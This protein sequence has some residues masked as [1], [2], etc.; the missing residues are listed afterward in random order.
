M[1][2]VVYVSTITTESEFWRLRLNKL[3]PWQMN[4]CGGL[5]LCSIET[6]QRQLLD[7]DAQGT[8]D[9]RRLPE[10]KGQHQPSWRFCQVQC[11]DGRRTLS[12]NVQLHSQLHCCKTS[13]RVARSQHSVPEGSSSGRH[14]LLDGNWRRPSFALLSSNYK[15][16]LLNIIESRPMEIVV[17][18]GVCR[19]HSEISLPV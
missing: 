3:K 2:S 8:H 5:G 16:N 12:Q 9:R 17:C 1:D 11:S 19:R 4:I 13:E 14:Q 7:L 18:P 10:I 15:R 6:Q